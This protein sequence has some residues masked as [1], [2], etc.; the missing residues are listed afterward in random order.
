MRP[1]DLKPRPPYNPE[2]P[3]YNLAKQ[4]DANKKAYTERKAEYKRVV[5]YH[6]AESQESSSSNSQS[7][8][9]QKFGLKK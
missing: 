4:E 7:S 3:P 5:H 9:A 2:R 1:N 6:K 8:F